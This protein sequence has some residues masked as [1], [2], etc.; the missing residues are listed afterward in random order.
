MTVPS[1]IDQERSL[2]YFLSFLYT[3]LCRCL[4]HTSIFASKKASY[5]YI[6]L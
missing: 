2:L 4:R 1:N 5:L 3:V 6:L